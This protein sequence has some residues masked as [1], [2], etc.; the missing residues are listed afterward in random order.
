MEDSEVRVRRN[1]L[2]YYPRVLGGMSDVD[3]YHRAQ[4]RQKH[5]LLAGPPGSGKTAGFEAA[6]DSVGEGEDFPVDTPLG[7]ETIVGSTSTRTEDFVGSYVQNPETR[8]FRLGSW[9]SCS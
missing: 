8:T 2:E 1:G 4:K 6:F 3:F 7:M 5:I 9:S